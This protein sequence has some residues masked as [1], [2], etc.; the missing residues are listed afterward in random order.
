MAE[1][2]LRRRSTRIKKKQEREVIVIDLSNSSSSSLESEIEADGISK[3]NETAVFDNP[4][5]STVECAVCLQVCVHPAKLPCGHIFCFLC[6]KGIAN[7]SKKCAMCRQEIPSDYLDK[8]DLVTIPGEVA[9]E[10]TFED[11]YQ[12]FY[13]GRNG[14]FLLTKNVHNFHSKVIFNNLLIIHVHNYFH[15]YFL[16]KER[17]QCSFHY[18]FRYHSAKICFFN[19]YVRYFLTLKYFFMYYS[20]IHYFISSLLQLMTFSISYIALG[21]YVNLVQ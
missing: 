3:T 13:E 7:Q 5:Q 2:N 19:P 8:P 21:Y 11:G 15:K 6:L 4:K 1:S 18:L 10:E 20:L 9:R 16:P 17:D 14:K 12:W